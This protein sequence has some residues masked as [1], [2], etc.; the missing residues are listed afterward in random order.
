LQSLVNA[1]KTDF[2]VV[3]RGEDAFFVFET[4]S[5]SDK[6]IELSVGKFEGEMA[7]S[8]MYLNASRFGAAISLGSESEGATLTLSK[9]AAK[10]EFHRA[11][12]EYEIIMPKSIAP[13]AR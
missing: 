3:Q 13:G 7:E 8:P 12:L 2:K 11:G 4:G 9:S 1:D 6:D 5:G 10:I